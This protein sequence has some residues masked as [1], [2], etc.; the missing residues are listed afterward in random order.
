MKRRSCPMVECGAWPMPAPQ[1][2]P[3]PCP[4]WTS[5]A[6]SRA[7]SRSKQ[8]VVQV[9]GQPARLI[10][11]K[12]IGATHGSDEQRVAGKDACR[13]IGFAHEQRNALGRVARRMQHVDCDVPDAQRLAVGRFVKREPERSARTGDDL[14]AKGRKLAGPGD[15]IGVDV[16]F[17]RVSER[18]P[19]SRR[20]RGVRVDVAPGSMT[21]AVRVRSQAIRNEL[22]ARPSSESLSN[23][24]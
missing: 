19:V 14:R 6:S 17:D 5:T 22:C 18:Q 9:T 10:G 8:R 15:E 1:S 7:I 24:R 2:E 13:S 3:A 4:G 12:Q 23:M 16:R 20:Y 21:A 11:A